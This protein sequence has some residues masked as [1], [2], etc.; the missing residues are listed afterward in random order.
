M[1]V[2][3]RA[4]WKKLCPKV[5]HLSGCCYYCAGSLKKLQKRTDKKSARARESVTRRARARA[6][7]VYVTSF[8]RAFASAF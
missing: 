6:P 4:G 3:Y 7:F 2:N 8:F 1:D 5:S